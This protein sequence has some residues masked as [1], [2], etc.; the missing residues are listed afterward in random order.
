MKEENEIHYEGNKTV[1]YVKLCLQYKIIN[2][3]TNVTS[4]DDLGRSSTITAT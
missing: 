3:K 4:P 2:S 1:V